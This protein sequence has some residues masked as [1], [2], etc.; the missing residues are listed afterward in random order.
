MAS[1]VFN[2]IHGTAFD[3]IA[4]FIAPHGL[5][6]IHNVKTADDAIRG[7]EATIK[8]FDAATRE[9][10]VNRFNAE[11]Y[12]EV[13]E[14]RERLIRSMVE[15]KNEKERFDNLRIALEED[16]E[17]TRV[18][19]AHDHTRE[20]MLSWQRITE[21]CKEYCRLYRIVTSILSAEARPAPVELQP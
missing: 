11:M 3:Y 8:A 9:G 4:Q 10:I 14:M 1:T 17:Y 13:M 21:S 7:Y 5:L 16:E 15:G 12:K 18:K 6:D 19:N 2:E 20:S